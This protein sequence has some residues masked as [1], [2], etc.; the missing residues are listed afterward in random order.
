MVDALIFNEQDSDIVKE[1]QDIVEF[2]KKE[3]KIKK[4]RQ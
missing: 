1:S 3:F 2:V 4:L